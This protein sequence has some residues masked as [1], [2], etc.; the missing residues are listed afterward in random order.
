MVELYEERLRE[1]VRNHKHINN[2]TSPG[3]GHR[4]FLHSSW[5]EIGQELNASWTLSEPVNYFFI[6]VTFESELRPL[7]L[8][9]H[10]NAKDAWNHKG[11]DLYTV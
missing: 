3:H 11:T 1:L 2:V 8:N 5:A 6:G 7:L 10:S 9:V 4:Q